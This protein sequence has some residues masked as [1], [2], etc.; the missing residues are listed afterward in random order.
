MK[1]KAK[2]ENLQEVIENRWEISQIGTLQRQF[3]G[4]EPH[5][6]NRTVQNETSP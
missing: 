4:F 5:R 1:K 3:A 6:N 2:L